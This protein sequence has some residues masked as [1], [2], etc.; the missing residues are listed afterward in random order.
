[1]NH[2]RNGNSHRRVNSERNPREKPYIAPPKECLKE[3]DLK[4]MLFATCAAFESTG[5]IR[6]M[7]SEL[8]KNKKK[9]E[10]N[11]N[12]A[13]LTVRDLIGKSLNRRSDLKILFEH[14]AVY[15]DQTGQHGDSMLL[16]SEV[17][18]TDRGV[19]MF[20]VL[21]EDQRRRMRLERE[22]RVEQE[23]QTNRSK[24]LSKIIK[25]IRVQESYPRGTSGIYTRFQR[26]IAE[27]YDL[28]AQSTKNIDLLETTARE[29]AYGLLEEVC[30]EKIMRNERAANFRSRKKPHGK[31]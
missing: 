3:D 28:Q 5:E 19:E 26:A 11:G 9:I 7:L 31:V 18:I 13:K 25:E 1:M 30:R 21:N 23:I 17:F 20:S 6:W 12:A 24:I 2:S 27:A 14:G 8:I 4:N 15:V 29:A 22:Q 16:N 10:T